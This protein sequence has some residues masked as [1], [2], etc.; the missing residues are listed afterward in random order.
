MRI[1]VRTAVLAVAA[2]LA[3]AQTAPAEPKN[4]SI[5]PWH[6]NVPKPVANPVTGVTEKIPGSDLSAE[7]IYVEMN[8]GSYSPIAMMKPAG[9]GRFPRVVL[10]SAANF[11]SPTSNFQGDS[12][13]ATSS[14]EVLPDFRTR[15]FPSGCFLTS[16]ARI[17]TSSSLSLMTGS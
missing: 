4:Y 1:L 5:D 13:A 2:G 16:V 3:A 14:L 10:A 15:Y 6:I 9:N 12:F 11:Q 8:D 7:I 17:F